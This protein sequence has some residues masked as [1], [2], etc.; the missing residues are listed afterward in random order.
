[1]GR[2]RER[3]CW[4]HGILMLP[5]EESFNV[6]TVDHFTMHIVEVLMC[7]SPLERLVSLSFIERK[8][9]DKKLMWFKTFSFPKRK[10]HWSHSI[11]FVLSSTVFMFICVVKALKA[12]RLNFCTS[13]RHIK[14]SVFHLQRASIRL[15][16]I[17]HKTKLRYNLKHLI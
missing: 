14:D 11:N 1:M 8:R 2:E 6:R 9:M 4:N 3:L 13:T 12:F 15:L 17:S 5:K 7:I 16:K 10:N